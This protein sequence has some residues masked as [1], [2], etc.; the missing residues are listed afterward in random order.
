LQVLALR[1]R[2]FARLPPVNGRRVLDLASRDQF[3]R[4]VLRGLE[5]RVVTFGQRLAGSENDQNHGH[6]RGAR[7]MLKITHWVLWRCLTGVVFC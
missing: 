2:N 1:R 3:A 6:Q 4:P 7:K 5:L